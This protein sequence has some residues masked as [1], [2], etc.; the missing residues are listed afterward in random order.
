[1]SFR[2]EID[3]ASG[4]LRRSGELVKLAP[5]QFRLLQFL[6][7]NPG[8]VVERQEIQHCDEHPWNRHVN[9]HRNGALEHS[10]GRRSTLRAFGFAHRC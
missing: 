1:M 6:V 7:R 2:F 8:R 9:E 3:D 5:R 10:W 4:E